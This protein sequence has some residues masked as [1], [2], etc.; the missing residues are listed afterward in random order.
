MET[1]TDAAQTDATI[2]GGGDM[3]SA[4]VARGMEGIVSK[5]LDA[6]YR[7]GR[8]QQWLKS[9][10]PR[11]D[12]APAPERPPGPP[13]PTRPPRTPE[14][15]RTVATPENGRPITTREDRSC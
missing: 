9:K 3:F 7:G 8:S 11:A 15:G 4:A 5:R 14:G 2:G 12:K 13:H 6:P 10:G 1:S